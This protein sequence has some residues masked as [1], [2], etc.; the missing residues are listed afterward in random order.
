MADP[1]RAVITG[2][3]GRMGSA[4]L[5]L[6]SE[7]D[8]IKPVQLIDRVGSFEPGAMMDAGRWDAVQLRDG[9]TR[10]SFD[11]L[12]DFSAP[13]ASLQF[14]EACVAT[15][16]PMVIGTTG[17]T[18]EQQAVIAAKALEIPIMQASNYSLGVALLTRLVSL[19]SATLGD[20]AD[21]EIVE[22]HHRRK[23]D[24]PSGTALSLLEAVRAELSQEPSV[25]DG[26]SGMVG[27]RSK[28]EI[29]MHALRGGDVVGEHSVIFALEGERIELTHRASTRT[30]FAQGAVAAAKWLSAQSSAGLYGMEHLIANRET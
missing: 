1:L 5:G 23:V 11:V 15:Q 9:L 3:Q 21:I 25:A 29:G 12:I 27:P 30:N 6:L 10:D 14:L 16:K 19:A 8:A 24:A 28:G 7:D 13:E 18:N 2:A 26:R 17:F 4:I 20:Q 22:M